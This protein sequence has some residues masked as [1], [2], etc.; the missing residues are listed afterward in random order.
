MA[1]IRKEISAHSIFDM[2]IDHTG[3]TPLNNAVASLTE[4]DVN[5]TPFQGSATMKVY[6]VVPVVNGFLVR[7][8]VDW[9]R[10]L[11]VRVT[12]IFE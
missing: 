12:V 10:N 8:E 6:N 3:V 2:R 5:G 4:L 7:G 11:R 1:S 9:D